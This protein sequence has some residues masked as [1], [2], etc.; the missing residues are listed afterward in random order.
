[1]GCNITESVVNQAANEIAELFKAHTRK[2]RDAWQK[3][4][5]NLNVSISCQWKP[6]EDNNAIGADIGIKFKMSEVNEKT[7]FVFSDG[8][9]PIFD[10]W[11][12]PIPKDARSRILWRSFDSLRSDIDRV[13]GVP[14]RF[15]GER[16]DK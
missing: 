4:A 9:G 3:T 10:T 6:V 12:P 14:D 8:F 7:Q 11:H 1:M 13:F 16:G 2:M 15:Q 5:G